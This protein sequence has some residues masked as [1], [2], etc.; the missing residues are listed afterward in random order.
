MAND[1]IVHPGFWRSFWPRVNSLDEARTA[2]LLSSWLVL[3]VAGILLVLA[4]LAA[5]NGA[6]APDTLT[7]GVG[8]GLWVAIGVGIRKGSRVAAVIGLVS[9]G[10]TIAD[11]ILSGGFP[12]LPSIILLLGLATAVRGTYGLKRFSRAPGGIPAESP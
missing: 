3:A 4:I 2:V 6:A 11:R 12:P 10:V 7:I 8:A 9:A 5:L 1:T